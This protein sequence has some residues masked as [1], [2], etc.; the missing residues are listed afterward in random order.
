M[1]MR[2]TPCLL[3]EAPLNPKAN[4]E[5]MTQTMYETFNI[6]A[7]YDAI[8]ATLS[9]YDSGC[10]IGIV[11][12]SGDGVRHT[13]PIYEGYALPISSFVLTLQNKI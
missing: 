1:L 10:T 5:K 6:P 12:D 9:L 7:M 3:N 2:G 8:Q 13:V 11:L 4:M